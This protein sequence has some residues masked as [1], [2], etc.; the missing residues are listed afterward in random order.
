ML[1]VIGY[2]CALYNSMD[3]A[4]ASTFILIVAATRLVADLLANFLANSCKDSKAI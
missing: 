2:L 4:L 1:F 3:F